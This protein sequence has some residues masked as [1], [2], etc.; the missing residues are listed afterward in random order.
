MC[1]TETRRTEMCRTEKILRGEMERLAMVDGAA[2]ISLEYEQYTAGRL[3]HPTTYYGYYDAN[4]VRKL[5]TLVGCIQ[6]AVLSTLN[7]SLA[8]V[9]A[10]REFANIVQYVQVPKSQMRK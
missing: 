6:G 9:P 2:L 7:R 10:Q 5:S 3:A 1:P 4:G 8:M